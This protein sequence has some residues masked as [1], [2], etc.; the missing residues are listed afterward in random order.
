MPLTRYALW[1]LVL[2][3]VVCS[4]GGC[5]EGAADRTRDGAA[6]RVVAT[7]SIVEDF[8]Q[9]VGG[10]VVDVRV[11]V[12]ADG[13][14]H[15]YDP[16]PRDGLALSDADLVFAVGRGFEPWL[17]G[18]LGSSRTAARVVE[19]SDGLR[20]RRGT[21]GHDDHAE[22]ADEA[23]HGHHHHG[24][25]DP[26]VWH[27]PRQVITMVESIAAALAEADPV[28]A[29]AYAARRDAYVAR[30]ELL[31]SY[32]AERVAELP[33][34]RRK[35]VTTHDAFGYF[36]DRYGFEVISLLGSVSTE[37]GDPSAA[38]MAAVA[39]RVKTAGVKAVFVENILSPK[40]TRRLA[41]QGERVSVA[42]LYS[43]ALGPTGSDGA[44][45]EQMMRHNVDAIV[46]A[47]R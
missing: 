8:V 18:L 29:A 28:N 15:T 12:P 45:Y 31:D 37:S 33:P 10:G 4:L 23:G 5:G 30:L 9:Q 6:L 24:D 21:D 39:D 2:A 41:E 34:E 3:T 17:V 46:E 25:A 32:I 43:D 1:F 27:D 36:A 7:S 42:S 22:H 11:L 26:H 38:A 44:T 20:E 19:L 35:L 13:D 47:L 40:L 16:T 14:V